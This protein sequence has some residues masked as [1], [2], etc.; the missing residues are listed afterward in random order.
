M[1]FAENPKL[2]VP[3]EKRHRGLQCWCLRS[4]AERARQLFL[5]SSLCM[6]WRRDSLITGE[7]TN[8]R[9][10]S[11][12]HVRLVFFLNWLVFLMLHFSNALC[13]KTQILHLMVKTGSSPFYCAP[14]SANDRF[15]LYSSPSVVK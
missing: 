2:A 11:K 7:A 15:F 9:G 14:A 13:Q 5:A 12:M 10:E 6:E 1:C 8:S 3:R 4:E